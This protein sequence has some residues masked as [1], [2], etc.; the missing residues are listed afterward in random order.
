MLLLHGDCWDL[1]QGRIPLLG[2][3]DESAVAACAEPHLELC[4][5]VDF[6]NLVTEYQ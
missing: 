3:L 6:L 5:N 2:M 4:R 1:L